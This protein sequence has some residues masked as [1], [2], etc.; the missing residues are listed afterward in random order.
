MGKVKAEISAQTYEVDARA[1]A[2]AILR[3]IRM[4]RLARR[5]LA[6]EPGRNRQPAR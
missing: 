4:V 6:N 2:D 1:V 3:R 5:E